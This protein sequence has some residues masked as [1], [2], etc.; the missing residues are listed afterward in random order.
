MRADGTRPN[1][2]RPLKFKSP[3]E[4]EKLINAYFD[5]CEPHPEMVTRWA[6]SKKTIINKKGEDEEVTNYDAPLYQE[7]REELT[8]GE[9]YTINGLALFLGT[10]RE[11]ILEYEDRP[12]FADTIKGAKTRIQKQLETA[13]YGNNVT[14]VIFNLK[15]NYGW[16][17]KTE[18]DTTISGSLATGEIDPEVGKRFGEFLKLDTKQ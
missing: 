17:D 18:V 10:N 4:L 14:G 7:T 12:Q 16:K 1:E 15:N 9:L 11:T 6:Y 2:G 5:S 3:E 8:R 13:L